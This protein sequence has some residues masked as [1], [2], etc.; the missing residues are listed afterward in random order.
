MRDDKMLDVTRPAHGGLPQMK[1]HMTLRK[2]QEDALTALRTS[3]ALRKLMVLPTGAGKTVVFAH[4]IGD[5]NANR[6][7]IIAHRKEIVEQ[8]VLTLETLY[9]QKRV[10]MLMAREREMD[11]DIVVASIQTLARRKTLAE[12]PTDIDLLVID[13]AHHATA[14]T[15]KRVLYRYGLM[16]GSLAGWKNVEGVTPTYQSNRRL[17]GVTATPRRTDKATLDVCFDEITYSINIP[18][19]IPDYLSDFR[20]ISVQSGVDLS[21]VQDKVGTGELREGEVGQAFLDSQF[22]QQLPHILDTHASDRQ[23]ILLFMPDVATTHAALETLTDACI[24]TACVTGT[25]STP[26]RTAALEAFR[27]G[28]VRVLV[29]CMVLTEGVDLP[30]IDCIVIARPTKSPALMVQMVGRGFRKHPDKQ[31]CLLID[32]AHARRQRDLL[33]VAGAG[34][35]G[36]LTD[37]HLHHPDASY[38][39]LAQM[40]REKLPHLMVLRGL[41]EQRIATMTP[42]V[43]PK[44]RKAIRKQFGLPKHRI[45]KALPESI[46]LLV[47]TAFLRHVCGTLD[48]GDVWKHLAHEFQKPH[49]PWHIEPSTEKQQDFLIDRG[50]DTDIVRTLKKGEA[51]ALITVLKAHQPPTTKQKTFLRRLGVRETAM[52]ATLTDATQMISELKSTPTQGIRT[53]RHT[54]PKSAQRISAPTFVWKQACKDFVAL[55]YPYAHQQHPR[56]T[57]RKTDATSEIYVYPG[58]RCDVHSTA[59][60]DCNATYV[61]S[62]DRQKPTAV[63]HRLWACDTHNPL[64]LFDKRKENHNG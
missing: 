39:E 27:Q 9:P 18:S 50:L 46:L 16:D 59:D 14:D 23:H 43:E 55:G 29:N 10:G 8:A 22:L 52:P 51:A 7:L 5:V 6:A 54:A 19:L 49:Y 11:A 34:L 4:H 64:V 40:Q 56:P 1:T 41:L 45:V 58:V 60:A 57:H 38:L 2:Y 62:I 15:Y 21:D 25:T 33:S 24:P 17:L 48:T 61:I 31:D 13:E 37:V 53:S 20:A 26:E 3:E 44:S 47:D 63:K 35:F 32:V 28:D 36:D 12:M 30:V 42:D